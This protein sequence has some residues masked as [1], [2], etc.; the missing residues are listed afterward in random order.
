VDIDPATARPGVFRLDAGEEYG[1][2]TSISRVFG[3]YK[4]HDFPLHFYVNG[5]IVD[6][7]GDMQQRFLGGSGYFNNVVRVSER[8]VVDWKTTDF[9][10]GVNG[11]FGPVEVDLSHS[12]KRFSAEDNILSF[13]YD[14]AG[15]PPGATRAAGTFP[16]NVLSD[17]EGS[18]NTLKIHSSYTGKIVAAATFSNFDRRNQTGGAESDYFI[19]AGSVKYMP[20]TNLSLVVRYRY[21]DFDVDNPDV[22]PAGYLGFPDYTAAITGVRDSISSR[23][24]TLST[25]IVYKPVKE[26]RLGLNAAYKD[27]DRRDEEAW[28]LPSSTKEKTVGLTADMRVM[29]NLK[30]G[31]GYTHK[32]FDDPAYNWQPNRSDSGRVSATYTPVKWLSAFLAFETTDENRNNL[33]FFEAVDEALDAHDRNVE[34]DKFTGNLTFAVLENLTLNTGYA[35]WHYKV[36]QDLVYQE[37]TNNNTLDTDVRYRDIARSYT[38]GLG[39]RPVERLDLAAGVTYTEADG[40]FFPKDDRAL[41]PVSIASFSKLKQSG[42][43][44]DFSGRYDVGKGCQVGLDYRYS[45]FNEITENPENPEESDGMAQIILLSVTK[46]W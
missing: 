30:L 46:R 13:D 35:Y 37:G 8:R 24:G 15:F 28:E 9:G 6:K 34:K 10:L 26:L 11:H 4:V 5:M 32:E 2:R 16:H 38:A 23:T 12:E 22:I 14:A 43:T 3:R 41:I 7:R 19:G 25:N 1:I 20:V 39:Y 21:Q 33:H 42:T 40:G 45:T 31:A 29:K 18:T 17:L 44:V 36:E 27:T